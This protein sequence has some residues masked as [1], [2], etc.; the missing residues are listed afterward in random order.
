M[1]ACG[2]K[3]KKKS[4]SLAYSPTRHRDQLIHELRTQGHTHR[5]IAR[6]L[7]ISKT[8]VA[9][10]LQRE[11]V[12]IQ[13]P[14]W[15]VMEPTRSPKLVVKRVTMLFGEEVPAA[16]DPGLLLEVLS[17]PGDASTVD[18]GDGAATGS[19]QCP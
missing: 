4:H 10:V 7:A 16:A 5:G 18:P 11:R 17:T 15:L 8:K 2:G 14:P 6:I 1:C 19:V 12:Y 9:A 3:M 13:I